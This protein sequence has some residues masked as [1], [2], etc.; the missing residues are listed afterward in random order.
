MGN[1]HSSAPFDSPDHRPRDAYWAFI[2]PRNICGMFFLPVTLAA[3]AVTITCFMVSTTIVVSLIFCGGGVKIKK[4]QAEY[5]LGGQN[6]RCG[7]KSA[8]VV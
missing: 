7:A 1:S 3:T 4:V 5:K 8:S 2:K 6:R